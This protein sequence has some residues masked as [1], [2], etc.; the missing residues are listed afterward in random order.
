MAKTQPTGIQHGQVDCDGTT[1]WT[2]R[3][4]F[5]AGALGFLGM[6]L[7]DLLRSTVLAGP[8]DVAKCDSV[9]L[10]WL[11]GGPSHIDTFDPKPG[12]PTNG[13][14]KA[15]DTSATGIQVCEHM[16]TI[17]RNMKHA[18]LIRSLT[19]K[20]G[21]HERA[22]YEM[23]TGYKPL[24]SIAH[25][26]LGSNVVAQKGKRNEEIPAYVS[27]GGNSFGA[28]FLGTQFAPFF[29]GNIENPAQNLYLDDSLGKSRD[30]RDARFRRRIDMLRGIDKEFHNQKRD[31][32]VDEYGRFY[33]DAIKMMYSKSLSAFNLKDEKDVERKLRDYGDSQLGKQVLM[34]RRLVEAG[35]RFVEVSMGGWDTHQNGFTAIEANLNKLDPAVGT[36]IEDLNSRGMLERTMVVCTGEFGRTPKINGNDGRDH[37]PRAWSGLIAGGGIKS[38]MAYG[39]TDAKG[40]EVKDN[41]VQI[42]DLHATI[43]AAL[44]IDWTHENQSPQGRPIRVVDK[45]KPI[46]A[47]LA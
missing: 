37:Y 39:A 8:N 44:G 30:E 11:A 40:E 22:T 20:E 21:A 4:F 41:P 28:G 33:S 46:Q 38:G 7:V 9:I 29:I 27:I 17:A 45:G 24:G 23:H 32:V 42:G 12:Q 43:C 5:K 15:I 26:S 36:L 16:P 1:G 25:P 14:Y 2:R 13:P 6:N 19:S 31:E 34:A 3:S 35:V 18:S 47:L 10:I